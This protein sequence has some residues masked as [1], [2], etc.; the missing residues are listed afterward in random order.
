MAPHFPPLVAPFGV[1][2]DAVL[3]EPWLAW[4][5]TA[6]RPDA[7]PASP[8]PAEADWEAAWPALDRH[9]LLPLLRSRLRESIAWDALAPPVRE[10][11]DAAYYANAVRSFG[12][13]EE[14]ER[15]AAALAAAG[16]AFMLL[17]GLAASR[18]VYASLA[19][20]LVNDLDL[21]VR[22]DDASA[23]VA[24]LE[25]LNYRSPSLDR[26]R[27]WLQRY[28]AELPLV[29]ADQGPRRGLLVELHWSLVESPFHV[30]TL[31]AAELWR[32]A[33]P[34]G[35]LP[36]AWLPDPAVLLLHGAAHLALHHSQ[37]LRLIWLVD[38]DRLAR[39]P[40]LR[41]DLVLDLAEAWRL[42]LALQASLLAAQRW[43]GTPLPPQA[44][45]RL[46]ALAGDPVARATWGVGDEQPGRW[47][48]RARAS[49]RVLP[50]RARPRYAAWLAGRAALRPLEALQARRRKP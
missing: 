11:L 23:A 41:W 1:A 7:A 37:S 4:L 33:R 6:L 38:L 21:L 9:G 10:R 40:T 8:P 28:R 13:E 43:L 17:K 46:E 39:L 24:A 15:I 5:A 35:H 50:P 16:A 44:L 2:A 47:W 12:L 26:P 18:L 22:P 30:A 45:D 27:G 32:T 36:N 3:P 14:L 49:W 48:R 20:R 31:N 34:A 25:A 29:C 19:E 42:G